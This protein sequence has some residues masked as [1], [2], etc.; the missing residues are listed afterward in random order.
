MKKTTILLFAVLVLIAANTMVSAQNDTNKT[1]A[2]NKLAD[3]TFTFFPVKKYDRD[4]DLTIQNKL[5]DLLAFMKD[6][7][8]EKM[9]DAGIVELKEREQVMQNFEK[10]APAFHDAAESVLREGLDFEKWVKTALAKKISTDFTLAELNELNEILDSERGDALLMV[11]EE[12]ESAN[13]EERESDLESLPID[14]EVMIGIA[15]FFIS[16]LGIKFLSIFGDGFE[17]NL[18]A[19]VT[20]WSTSLKTRMEQKLNDGELGGMM[21]KFITDNKL[22][23]P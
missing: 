3:K 22:K 16:P 18:T 1:F 21:K 4:L 11:F 13:S 10:F 17:E 15:E 20:A 7:L 23:K 2:V 12:I 9:D 5:N 14:E 8:P 19:E 6:S